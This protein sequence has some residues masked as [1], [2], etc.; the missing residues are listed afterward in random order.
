MA[1]RLFLQLTLPLMVTFTLCSVFTLRHSK[2]VRRYGL[3][4]VAVARQLYRC[5]S[6]APPPIRAPN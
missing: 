5:V 4:T 6:K 1:N 3:T 2:L